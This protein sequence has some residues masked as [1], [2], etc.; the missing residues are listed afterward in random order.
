MVKI[1]LGCGPV[2]AKGWKNYDWGL[3]PILGKYKVI[4]LFVKWGLLDKVYDWTWPKIELVD[5]RKRLPDLDNSV[6]YIYCSHVLEHFEKD[7][8]LVIL[9]ECKRVLKKNGRIR[10]VLPDLDKMIKN[11]QG[12]QS[13]NREYFGFDK[14]LY[15]GTIGKIKRYFIRSH[16]WMYD[17]KHGQEL[18]KEAGFKNVYICTFRKGKVPD[19]DI[20]D[21]EQHKK[22]SFYLEAGGMS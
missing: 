16:Q 14:D 3:L 7:V 19:K 1:N 8:A 6:D 18:L 10:I 22:T 17:M 15:I 9:S 12:A 5:I 2:S 13:F 4:K 11:Y 20:L 21:I